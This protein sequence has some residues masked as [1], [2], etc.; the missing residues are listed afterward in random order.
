M[1][2]SMYRGISKKQLVF[3]RNQSVADV[4]RDF[5]NEVYLH[6]EEVPPQ[7]TFAAS[8]KGGR[9]KTKMEGYNGLVTLRVHGLVR[10]EAAEMR[11]KVSKEPNTFAAFV[12]GDGKGLVILVAVTRPDGSLPET[13]EEAMDFQQRASARA[14]VYYEQ[15]LGVTIRQERNLLIELTDATADK[16]L[17]YNPKSEVLPVA[18]KSDYERKPEQLMRDR[19]G[20]VISFAHL[21]IGEE[22]DLEVRRAFERAYSNAL[23]VESF[24]EGNRFQFAHALGYYCCLSGIP[25]GEALPLAL[26]RCVTTLF[27]KEDMKFSLR[28]RYKQYEMN[29][30][31]DDG[32][33]RVERE[34]RRLEQFIRREC[35][36]RRNLILE[37]IEFRYAEQSN[38]EWESL[39]DAHLNSLYFRA[40]KEGI[41]CTLNDVKAMVDSE[42][43]AGYHP[44]KEY[45]FGYETVWDGHN[46]I[47]DVAATVIT[48]DP[49]FFEW[50][51][52]KWFV[53]YVASLVND[54]VINHE[55]L[56]LIGG[57]HGQGKSTWPERLLPPEWRKNYFDANVFSNNPNTTRIKLST[58][59]LLN[60]DELD[61]IRR[62][63]QDAVKELFTTFNINI[64]TSPERPSR[65][66][67]R[68]ASFFG[69]TNHLDILTDYTG[70][71]RYLCNE[72]TGPINFNFEINYNQL[73][74]QAW[75][76]VKNNF[77][78]YFN[79]EDNERVELHNQRFTET[80]AD[81]DLF[82]DSFRKPED[83]EDGEYL[84]AAQLA[85]IIHG[86]TKIAVSRT[87]I[88]KLG[89]NL[90]SLKYKF[91]K[92]SGQTQYYVV[93]R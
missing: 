15:L 57:K 13:A 58:C 30:G 25:E 84:S 36:V 63:D 65:N 68:H 86:K 53:A 66:F 72:V 76:M 18:S 77:R 6:P 12:T 35:Q 11:D 38:Y 60:I 71:R 81:M 19:S 39:R 4:L 80:D 73:Y 74:A 50:C 92:Y 33:S 49:E 34:T 64:R 88:R 32:V 61:T 5:K 51:F 59:A 87:M 22:R 47:K 20:A 70:S 54:R 9:V 29:Q 1:N 45:L 27:T 10:K 67:V 93:L 78:Y 31:S 48:S 44:F 37:D 91:R 89:H 23:E 7:F 46:Y 79:A 2:I 75:E 24:A 42:L 83:D 90:K 3:V 40:H 17:Y 14:G 8:F 62:Y 69:T 21:P 55:I 28:V 56:V 85:A 41:V 43:T 26:N 52:T 16:K 82:Y